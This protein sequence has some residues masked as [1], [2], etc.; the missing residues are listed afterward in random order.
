M[1]VEQNDFKSVEKLFRKCR[2]P[3][4]ARCLHSAVDFHGM[5]VGCDNR[6]LKVKEIRLWG[7][8][9]ALF[10]LKEFEGAFCIPNAI[11]RR[12]Q[13]EMIQHALCDCISPSNRSN[14]HGHMNHVELSTLL[15][16]L[17]ARESVDVVGKLKG[18][19]CFKLPKSSVLSKLRWVTLGK[20]SHY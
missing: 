19:P 12:A 1:S 4:T 17:W 15:S 3:E 13:V 6:V 14:L 11:P 8:S 18:D 9:K 7:R 2:N 5:T 16:N 20:P 10:A